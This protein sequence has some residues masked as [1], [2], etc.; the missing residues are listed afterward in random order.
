MA[1]S[2]EP[3]ASLAYG[4]LDLAARQRLIDIKT[5]QPPLSRRARLRFAASS[6]ACA[7]GKGH[8]T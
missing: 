8:T 7:A 6:R 5:F 3:S 1:S 4:R 2:Q